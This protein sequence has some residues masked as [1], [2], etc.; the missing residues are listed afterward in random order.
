MMKRVLPH[1][2]YSQRWQVETTNSML[3]RLLGSAL[4]PRSYWSQCRELLLRAL[5]LN[6]MILRRRKVFDRAG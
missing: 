3:K 2:H 4:R 5:T 1:S 6:T